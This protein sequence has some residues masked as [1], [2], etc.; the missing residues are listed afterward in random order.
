MKITIDVSDLEL[1]ELRKAIADRWVT[2]AD[3]V[4]A[5]P[6][7]DKDWYETRLSALDDLLA[8]FPQD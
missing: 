5:V 1:S 8:R 4:Y 6:A 2:L 7:E 3:E